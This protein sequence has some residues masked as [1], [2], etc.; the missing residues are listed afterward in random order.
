M[1]K[2]EQARSS[3][4]KAL[5]TKG[6]Q[7][8]TIDQLLVWAVALFTLALLLH[9]N[10]HEPSLFTF[11]INA[12]AWLS[13]LGVLAN[14]GLLL[15]LILRSGNEQARMW[16][17]VNVSGSMIWGIGEMF[18]RLST[19]A[20]QA[21]F[22]A[23]VS[24]IGLVLI[25]TGFYM[26]SRYYATQHAGQRD[27]LVPVI[28]I[29][30]T[31]LF[32]VMM[33]S[34][35]TLHNL[36]NDLSP[37]GYAFPQSPLLPLLSVWEA[38]ILGLGLLR[39][40]RHFRNSTRPDQ[41]AQ[42]AI[43]IAA[44]SFGLLS[45][46]LTDEIPRRFGL[47]ILP[48]GVFYQTITACVI[49]YAIF[50]YDTFAVDF[51]MV[52]AD[53]LDTLSEAVVVTDET[54]RIRLANRRALE[55]T[56][57]NQETMY[58]TPIKHIFGDDFTQH[59]I[60]IE[61]K[62][63]DQ[64][65]SQIGE[66]LLKNKDGTTLSVNLSVAKLTGSYPAY[67]F[68]L[69][70]ISQVKAYYA[71]E[72][73]HTQELESANDAYRQQQKAMV[74]L[75]EDARDLEEQLK[76]EKAGVE[77]KV[78]RATNEIQAERTRLEASINSLNLG[79]LMVDQ[80]QK[81]ITLN[82]AAK[83]IFGSQNVSSEPTVVELS[84]DLAGSYDLPKALTTCLKTRKET[85]VNDLLVGDRVLRIFMAP[86]MDQTATTPLG[87]VVLL[88]DISEA[89]AMER[90]R[91]EFFSIAS[92][93]LRTPLTAIRGNTQMMQAYYADQFKDPTLKEMLD[94]I[95]DSSIRLITIVND[96]L[97]TSRLE[98]GKI[99]FKITE[100]EPLDLVDAVM[101]EF[102]AGDMNHELYL[103]VQ[104]PKA[105]M[106]II[107]ADYDRLKQVLI[108]L[109]GNSLKFTEK[110]GVTIELDKAD[111]VVMIRV[112]D[113]GK[114]VPQ[115]SQHLL[116]RKFQQASNNILTRD[117]TRSTGLGLYISRLIMQG[118]GGTV[119]LEKSELDKGSTFTI[120]VPTV[121]TKTAKAKTTRRGIK[122]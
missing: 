114:G 98:Q 14:I 39:F 7:L 91:D 2:L 62:L 10:I 108:N 40:I 12:Y 18:E 118:M 99:E 17:A 25:P 19:S 28:L 6:W 31:C 23:H 82:G 122:T 45:T 64:S 16:Y 33:I 71:R 80:H 79:F 55:L 101:K 36:G 112:V 94:D 56:G 88:D 92:H 102:K 44:V 84:K 105:K 54:F 67:L 107:R 90:S 66:G 41:R 74:N 51:A 30:I 24:A 89:K 78:E 35:Q 106:P 72:I 75:L 52:A 21:L 97:D 83:K 86:I 111:G 116:F 81:V 77:R 4:E 50:R 59:R 1:A 119:Y 53:I 49:I 93:E 87:A 15:A 20:P 38:V 3:I 26:F 47:N 5:R 73:E 58:G 96:F 120:E 76:R 113:T 69:S 65:T 61:E 121:A 37:W 48:L 46:L 104:K 68:A 103:K 22:W 29:L 60:A 115:A 34:D 42:S 9:I 13:A 70:D 11:H 27:I 63:T 100:F 8:S 109:V 95:H 43:I 57:Y 117:S 85:V 110:G 32:A